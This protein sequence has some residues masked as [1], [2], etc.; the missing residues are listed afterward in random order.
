MLLL[1]PTGSGRGVPDPAFLLL[2]HDNPASWTS[3]I[4][5]PGTVFFPNTKS[6]AKALVNPASQV[7]V[8]SFPKSCTV[9]WPNPGSW[10][11]P[12]NPYPKLQSATKLVET[13]FKNEKIKLSLLHPLHAMLCHCSSYLKTTTNTQTWNG[14]GEETDVDCFVLQS[15][16][17]PFK[18][19]GFNNFAASCRHGEKKET[20]IFIPLLKFRWI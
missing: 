6:R 3:V 4:S 9:F 8:K 12:S 5:T 15:C 11:Y 13:L 19:Q 18:G 14:W 2:F 16:M 1:Y 10:G 7:S 17:Y 20:F